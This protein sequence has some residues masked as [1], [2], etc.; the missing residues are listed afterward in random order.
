[1]KISLIVPCYN[2]EQNVFPFWQEAEKTFKGI[3]GGY[4]VIFVN[5]GSSDA[6]LAN[7]KKIHRDNKG[8]VTVI[9]FSRNF[10]KEAA[11]LAGME[12]ACGDYVNVIDADLQQP[13]GIV[14]EMVEFLEH[15]HEYDAVAAYQKE[16]SEGK[17]ISGMKNNFYKLINKVCEIE[18][19]PGASDFRTLRSYVVE[20]I[21]SM[22]EYFRFS[23]GIFSWVGFETY[24]M[25]YKAE[26][27]YAGT[28]KWTFFKLLRYAFEGFLSFTTFPLKI[29]VY[30]GTVISFASLLYMIVVFVQKIFF[31]IDIPGYPTIVVL[32]LLLGGIQLLILGIMGEYMAR[33]YIQGKNR[34]VYIVKEYIERSSNS[35]IQEDV[36]Q[37]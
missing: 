19:Y 7:L 24:Y 10:G 28:S 8:N 25:P 5:D 31:S 14:M 18:F 3:E 6:T 26:K 35:K 27:R 12:K 15:H 20:A 29:A 1:L 4:E 30:L 22:K 11:I 2:E 34:P 13:P 37:K 32:I 21:I 33:I 17:F 36:T 23:K 16:R 9:S